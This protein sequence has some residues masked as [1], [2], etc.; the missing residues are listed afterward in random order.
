MLVLHHSSAFRNRNQDLTDKGITLT[1]FTTKLHMTDI[2]LKITKI[3]CDLN[4][5]LILLPCKDNIHRQLWIS[6]LINIVMAILQSTC[7]WNHPP[8]RDNTSS[9]EIRF[10]QDYIEKLSGVPFYLVCYDTS[11]VLKYHRNVI[12]IIIIIIVNAFS[13]PDTFLKYLYILT[14]L[15]LTITLQIIHYCPCLQIIGKWV[16]REDKQ[17]V[18][19]EYCIYHDSSQGKYSLFLEGTLWF[20]AWYRKWHYQSLPNQTN[21]LEGLT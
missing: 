18:Q 13:M 16:K 11:E 2:S 20:A 8:T 10:A 5:W 9:G 19:I 4:H 1:M 7:H 17:F 12:K 6:H 3:K 15:I 21:T 14:Y